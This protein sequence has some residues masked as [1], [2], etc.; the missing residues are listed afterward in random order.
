MTMTLFFD[1]T[2]IVQVIKFVGV[3]ASAAFETTRRRKV[4]LKVVKRNC[5]AGSLVQGSQSFVS[6]IR[7]NQSTYKSE[8]HITHSLNVIGQF[9]LCRPAI[10]NPDLVHRAANRVLHVRSARDFAFGNVF[11]PVDANPILC[12]QER[13]HCHCRAVTFIVRRRSAAANI[14][15]AKVVIWLWTRMKFENR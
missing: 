3:F 12:A 4:E 8:C 13:I 6:I 11:S 1:H 9:K 15:L 14:V 5:L 10:S 2:R 7:I